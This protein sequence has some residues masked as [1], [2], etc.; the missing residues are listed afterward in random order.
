MAEPLNLVQLQTFVAIADC[1]GFGRAAVAIHLSQSTVSEHVRLLEQ[2]LGHA[3]VEKDGRRSRFTEAG[4]RLLIEARRVLAVRDEALTISSAS[5]EAAP[6]LSVRPRR[7][8]IRC[9]R[10]CWR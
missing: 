6:S 3:L 1:G 9:C 10:R 8:R 5:G 7:R 2:R 4:E